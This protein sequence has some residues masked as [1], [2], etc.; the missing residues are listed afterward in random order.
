[1]ETCILSRK[2]KKLLVDDSKEGGLEVITAKISK[3]VFMSCE[4]KAG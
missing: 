3:N 2:A 1:M 4:Q